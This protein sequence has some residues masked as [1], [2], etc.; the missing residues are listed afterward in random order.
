MGLLNIVEVR[1]STPDTGKNRPPRRS[2]ESWRI[3]DK[4]DPLAKGCAK[5]VG[6][7][8]SVSRMF[9]LH[10][11]SFMGA[12]GCYVVLLVHLWF[13][14]IWWVPCRLTSTWKRNV[15]NSCPLKIKKGKL[16][17]CHGNQNSSGAQGTPQAWICLRG[18][19]KV[20]NIFPIDSPKGGFSME[21]WKKSPETN[22]GRVNSLVQP[23]PGSN[24]KS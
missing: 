19:Q 1:S 24:K 3:T 13:V 14:R 15:I 11:P 8:V 4:F 6:Q 17:L 18:P 5:S 23:W 22:L 10:I 2:H 7:N 21:K 16:M 20:K 12:P 9:Y